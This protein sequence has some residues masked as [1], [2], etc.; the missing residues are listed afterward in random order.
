MGRV[1]LAPC[2]ESATVYCI[3]MFPVQKPDP[4]LL[5]VL[6]DRQFDA[7]RASR[8]PLQFQ[9]DGRN[10]SLIRLIAGGRVMHLGF[11]D[12]GPL[13]ANKRAQG[14]WLH[15]QVMAHSA[16]CIGVDINAEAV[17]LA[18][19]LGVPNLHGLDVF[20]PEF[21]ELATQFAP[22][23]VLLPDVLEH[24]HEPVAFVR[25]LAQVMPQ[26]PLVVSVPN[27]L[28]LRN[29]WNSLAQ[30][31]RINTDHLCWYSPFTVAKVLS[32]GGYTPELW[33]GTQIAPAASPKGRVLSAL[34]AWRPLW[35][36]NILV[37]SR[38]A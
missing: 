3:F 27:G 32:R 24:L 18:Q 31:E 21:A 30:V 4:D 13:I 23:H 20:S 11:A 28:S 2:L 7:D 36:D 5:D 34:A 14:T 16:A 19:G 9:A 12:H 33:W 1:A 10:A 8:L 15:D 38:P 29:V 22:T 35:A 17:A 37:L 26:V 6:N 25:R